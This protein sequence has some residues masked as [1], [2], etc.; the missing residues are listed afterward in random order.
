MR[1]TMRANDRGRGRVTTPRRAPGRPWSGATSIGG[2]AGTRARSG[3]NDRAQRPAR[4]LL[5][6]AAAAGVLRAVGG[7]VDVR[8]TPATT[9]VRAPWLGRRRGPGV[10]GGHRPERRRRGGARAAGG[11][12]SR[13]HTRLRNVR[14]PRCRQGSARPTWHRIWPAGRRESPQPRVRTRGRGASLPRATGA[15]CDA[16]GASCGW[17]R[18]FVARDLVRRTSRL[19]R[20]RP[21][22]AA[23]S[24]SRRCSWQSP[25][26]A[27]RRRCCRSP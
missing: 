3:R 19:A 18:R 9:R 2:S 1:A 8:R 10:R 12:A 17:L 20:S 21:W 5:T 24:R 7:A 11:F 13:R 6:A 26:R 23:S 4:C 27:A 14:G 25:A 15:T 16:I 22:P